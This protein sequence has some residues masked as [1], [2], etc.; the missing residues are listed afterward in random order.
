VEKVAQH[1]GGFRIEP[2]LVERAIHQLHPA[3]ARRLIDD[4]RE[5]PHSQARMASLLDVSRGTT[6]A[7]DQKIA[8]AFFGAAQVVRRVHRPED[9]IVWYLSIK[10]VHQPGEA[11]LT[12]ARIDLI[13]SQSHNTYEALQRLSRIAGRAS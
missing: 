13:L 9:V 7:A 2:G 11:V 6:K 10:G 8:E 12:D 4:E 3:I 1:R 5:V